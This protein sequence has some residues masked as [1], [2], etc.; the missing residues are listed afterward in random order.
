M[1]LANLY[2]L[3]IIDVLEVR[4]KKLQSLYLLLICLSV[5]ITAAACIQFPVLGPFAIHIF[6]EKNPHIPDAVNW[7]DENS[8]ELLLEM[9]LSHSDFVLE[10]DDLISY[11]WTSQQIFFDTDS[12]ELFGRKIK[13]SGYYVVSLG[14]TSVVGGAILPIPSAAA[15]RMPIAYHNATMPVSDTTK[16]ELFIPPYATESE[17]QYNMIHPW[18]ERAIKQRVLEIG[19]LI[20][21][22]N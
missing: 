11:N 1:D 15:P 4:L 12:R 18:M 2:D 19:K 8:W 9:D 5:L 20:E 14:G 21:T 6:A 22:N 13:R 10:E 3:L 7:G 17:S 16:L